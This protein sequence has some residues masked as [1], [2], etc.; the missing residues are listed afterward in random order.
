MSADRLAIAWRLKDGFKNFNSTG[1]IGYGPNE[2]VFCTQEFTLHPSSYVFPSIIIRRRRA[3]TVVVL[4]YIMA[5][6]HDEC[7][8]R[9]IEFYVIV[10]RENSKI[11]LS[12]QIVI[13]L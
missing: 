7:A 10:V 9:D 13:L 8:C 5:R 2:N 1:F 6:P 11:L 3:A 12:M 4:Y